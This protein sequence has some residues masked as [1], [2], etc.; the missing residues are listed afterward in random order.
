MQ[1]VSCHFENMPGVTSCG[2]CGAN[3]MLASSNI[4]VYPPRAGTWAK[5]IRRWFRVH[6]IWFTLK[7]INFNI[8]NIKI[9]GFIPQ[10]PDD[11]SNNRVL[12]KLWVPGWP[13]MAL[14]NKTRGKVML[15]MYLAMLFLA[16]LFFGSF[17]GGVFLGLAITIHASSVFDIFRAGIAD[18]TTLLTR[19]IMCLLAVGMVYFVLISYGINNLIVPS[20]ITATAEPFLA[21]DTI[22]YNPNAYRYNKP[23]ISEVVIYSI[24]YEV[25]NM[26]GYREHYVYRIGGDNI[27]R[28]IAGEGQT[29]ELAGGALLVDDRPSTWQPLNP[30]R[31]VV[32]L[33]VTVPEG[34]Y[35]I[36]PS[37]IPPEVNMP[38][39]ILRRM[40]LVPRGSVYGRA[41]LRNYP[42]SR[43]WW[44]R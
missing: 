31:F 16:L 14:G 28:I 23:A 20:S 24:P 12:S 13:Q 38:E 25:F 41:I 9:R 3:L 43:W 1:C 37:T 34:Y 30:K 18:Y 27:D 19:S 6:R 21:G 2:R 10:I 7:N 32:N 11:W 29:V 4:N 40:I 36:L 5:L 15:Y 17:P 8:F 39:S 26:G 22:L 33:K 44:I 42:F 35:C